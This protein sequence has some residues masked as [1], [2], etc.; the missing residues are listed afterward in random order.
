M[1]DEFQ[2]S[3]VRRTGS[4]AVVGGGRH[5]LMGLRV[6]EEVGPASLPASSFLRLPK[7]ELDRLEEVYESK[8]GCE[9]VTGSG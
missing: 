1:D 9:I 6:R 5:D 4:A 3:K 7:L 8:Y 2:G